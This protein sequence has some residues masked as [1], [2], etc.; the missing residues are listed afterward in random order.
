MAP[1]FVAHN[2]AT[3]T[4]APDITRANPI[5]PCLPALINLSPELTGLLL[6]IQGT[7]LVDNSR[8]ASGWHFEGV[9][10]ASSVFFFVPKYIRHYNPGYP[11]LALHQML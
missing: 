5:S 8:L 1:E 2:D 9:E 7:N 11:F 3:S 4:K 10:E 6:L